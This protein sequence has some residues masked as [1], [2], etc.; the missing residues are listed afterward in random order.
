MKLTTGPNVRYTTNYLRKKNFIKVLLSEQK[1]HGS[2]ETVYHTVSQEY[3]N[4]P[5]HCRIGDR[6]EAYGIVL[7]IHMQVSKRP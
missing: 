4:A 1:C 6:F 3:T 5:H 7:D 2:A